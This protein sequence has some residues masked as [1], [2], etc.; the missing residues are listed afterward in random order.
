MTDTE[1]NQLR[2]QLQRQFQDMMRDD[3]PVVTQEQAPDSQWQR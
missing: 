3:A 2:Q 1:L